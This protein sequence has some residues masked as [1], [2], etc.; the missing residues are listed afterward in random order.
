MLRHQRAQ[1]CTVVAAATFLLNSAASA[2]ALARAS[3]LL[4]ST[5]PKHCVE[6]LVVSFFFFVIIMLTLS[7]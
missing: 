1:P 4:G 7:F 3:L 2:P 5:K 6:R